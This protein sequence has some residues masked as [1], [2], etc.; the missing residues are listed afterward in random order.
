ML[1]LF[2]FLTA[3]AI[4]VT[5]FISSTTSE[6][7]NIIELHQIEE[8]RRSL[9]SD[10]QNVQADI[11][12]IQLLDNNELNT[13]VSNVLVME[14]TSEQ[15]TT[16]HHSPALTERLN[17]V[18][19]LVRK[20]GNTLSFY[21]TVDGG[22]KEDFKNEAIEIGN[23]LIYLTANMSREASHTLE[24]LTAE[25]M[26][27][28]DEV[29]FILFVTL[30]VAFLL[31]V[32]VAI[33]LIRHVTEPVNE[34][35]RATRMITSGKLGTVIEYSDRTEFGELA[36]HFNK[37][38]RAVEAGYEKIKMEVRVR[39]QAE[40]ALA[41]SEKFFRSTF[42]S[43]WDPLC[44]LDHHYTVVRANEAYTEL[45]KGVSHDE[46]GKHC[47]SMIKN[48][49][50]R[51]KNCVVEKTFKSQDPCAKDELIALKD[52]SR[53]W[54]EIYTYPIFN[55][56]GEVEHVVEYMRDITDRKRAEE[57]LRKSEERY[58]LAAKGANDGLW[59]WDAK[60]GAVYY[61]SRWRSILGLDNESLKEGLD[62]WLKRIHPEE[63]GEVK[64]D[65][66]AHMRG[67][68]PHFESEHRVLHK[69]GTYRWVIVRGLCVRNGH[70]I[71]GSI[72]DITKRKK[73]EEQLAYEAMHDSLTGLPNRAL[74][75]DRLSHAVEREKRSKNYM[76][77][78]IFVDMDRFKMVNDSLG[79]ALGDTLL[80]ALSK[81]LAESLRPGDTVAR[82]GGDEFAILLEDLKSEREAMHITKR[83]Q[84]KMAT[85]FNIN[86]QEVYLSASI[87]ITFS[88]IGYD[89][90]ENLLR[91][92]DIAMYQ[93]KA[94]GR[95]RQEIFDTVMYDNVVSRMNL[96]RDLRRAIETGELLLHYQPI[97]SVQ[98][99]KVAAFEALVRWSHPEHG[100][101]LPSE[102]IP[103][104][105]DSG[106]IIPLGKWVLHEACRQM[107]AW[108]KK[109]LLNGTFKICV[110]I[111]SRQFLPN[112]IENIKEVISHTGLE[113]GSLILEITESMIMENTD[114]VFPLCEQ[115]K[116]MDVQIHID[117]FGT[118]YSSLS[119]LHNFPI[120]VLKIDR[121]FIARVGQDDENMKILRAIAALSHSMNIGVVA[122][123][124]ET[125]DQFLRLKS[126]KCEFMQGYFFS[127][128]L[129]RT[130]AEALL[131]R[132]KL[133]LVKSSVS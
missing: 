49:G 1:C 96:E 125:R 53:I 114:T 110:N 52:G 20:Y 66:D 21:L 75:M 124:V 88:N 89:H 126:L 108:Q 62:E 71:A 48:R 51:C 63:R 2:I 70:R 61:S 55:D 123:G 40:K 78:V 102:F 6:L 104:A 57:E 95:S 98:S 41:E 24:E 105:E 69:D 68:T 17:N 35:V 36:S 101:I 10:I 87:G 4:T 46:G 76:F 86:G 90:P 72:T 99:G 64:T 67:V 116:E 93:A 33:R 3:G 120:D 81:R 119:Y 56:Y 13:V 42:D 31:G 18:Q 107:S 7:R 74:F 58:A 14:E 118:G 82:F 50:I 111:S 127:K 128:P 38:S 112:L 79:H 91:D 32:I 97:I 133:K 103:M 27:R 94:K 84:E 47:L 25:T 45:L 121:S 77:A 8:L 59:D 65:L 43:T 44:I 60:T 129:D 113:Q 9:V 106:L 19:S 15:C 80:I 131:R 5:L 23:E 37:M 30:L 83:I 85:P 132:N 28:I 130:E 12:A 11:Y 115:L 117:D 54:L 16:C 26:S 22:K 122:E 34:M 100:V 109:F 92:A 73:I 39:R 29:K